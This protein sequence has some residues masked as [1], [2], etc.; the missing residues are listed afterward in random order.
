[1][2]AVVHPRAGDPHE[3][4]PRTKEHRVDGPEVETVALTHE[5]IQAAIARLEGRYGMTSAEFLTRY[6]QGE[7]DDAPDYI[8]WAGLLYAAATAPS[9]PVPQP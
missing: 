5:A 8:E 2:G 3:L 4:T 6:H 9:T 7:L 1:M